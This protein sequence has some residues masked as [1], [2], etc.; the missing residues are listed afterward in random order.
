MSMKNINEDEIIKACKSFP[1]MASAAA[2]LS[3]APNTFRRYAMK[4]GCYR[5]NQ[6]GIGLP[7]RK[8]KM[9][10]EM[11]ISGNA[12]QMQSYKIKLRL[13]EEG[14]LTNK[15]VECGLTDTYN[16]KPIKLQLDHINGIST[17]HRLENLRIVCPNCHSQTNSYAGKNC[18]GV[19]K[20]RLVEAT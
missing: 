19:T 14:Y 15:C 18:R 13:I 17:D 12:P 11:I 8:P 20:S 9:P 1:S 16:G 2:S 4:L 10:T 7:K 6:A 3:M 5:P